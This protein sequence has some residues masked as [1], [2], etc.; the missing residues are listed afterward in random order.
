MQVFTL[1]V[2]KV[3]F[4]L[5]CFCIKRVG[6]PATAVL[7]LLYLKPH[8]IAAVFAKFHANQVDWRA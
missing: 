6:Y 5:Q 4:K 8:N 7:N 2:Y 1:V 3:I